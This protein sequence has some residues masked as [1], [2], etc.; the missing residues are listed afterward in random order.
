M[1]DTRIPLGVQPMKIE[2]PLN[3]M[4]RVLELERA[5][6]EGE[7]GQMK[8]DEYRRGIEGQNVLSD[9]YRLAMRPDGTIDR[10]L[11]STT[12]AQRNY[13]HKLPDIMKS[14]DDS[15]KSR[16]GV[17]QDAFKLAKERHDVWKSELG[18]LAQD[19]N[20]SKEKAVQLGQ[21]LVQRGIVPE[22]MYQQSV[23]SMPD[24]PV[25]LRDRLTQGLKSQMTAEQIFTVFAPKPKEVGDGQHKW[26]QDENPNSPTYG[27]PTGAA[28]IQMHASPDAKLTDTRAREFNETKVEENRLKR[29][30]KEETAN[31]TK[32]SQIAS[33]E[34]MLGTL[35]R[36]QTHP[37][38]KR[39]VG[40]V[41]KFP[42]MPGSESANFEAELNTFKSQAFIP[43][44]A[45][46]KGMGAL[47]DAEGKK[48]SDAVGALD[49]KMGEQAFRSSIDRIIAD[50]EAGY[51]RLSGKPRPRRGG[52]ADGSW[53]DATNA[54]SAPKRINSKAEMDALPPGAEF[55]APDG[56]VR[57]KP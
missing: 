13:G 2:N 9:A 45:Q 12:V 49:P 22:A 1:L 27:R 23:A 30:Q 53:G 26:W 17:Q 5:K 42:T 39:S 46:L 56:T 7:L 38:L 37:G 43:M 11:L 20:L 35:E 48:L 24:D 41:G 34:T 25:Q 47:S 50:M 8:M 6:Q 52:G 3:A 15:E 54:P 36:L 51:T 57:R 28:P 44:I 14:L 10:N 21:S 55:I 18:A 16:L 33:F 19:P 40:I 4:A 31:L 29:E 32:Q